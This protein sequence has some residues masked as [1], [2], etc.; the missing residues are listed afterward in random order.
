ML[1]L[2]GR[3]AGTQLASF[4]ARRSADVRTPFEAALSEPTK[5]PELRA[6]RI[7]QMLAQT[8]GAGSASL[9]LVRNGEA[10]R[11]AVVGP[12]GLEAAGMESLA[13]PAGADHCLTR[14]LPLG[15]D[16]FARLELRAVLGQSLTAEAALVFA[17]CAA[18][19]GTWLAGALSSFDVPA[20]LPYAMAADTP[21][22]SARIQEELERARRFDFVS[23]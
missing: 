4:A 14:V 17:A 15:R 2:V 1:R 5:A 11:I 19:L 13:A 12:M 23:P 6:M 22:F 16:D 10:R 20:T 18:V 8:V 21:G 9:T 7:V 3:V